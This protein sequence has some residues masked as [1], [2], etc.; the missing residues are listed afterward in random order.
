MIHLFW[1]GGRVPTSIRENISRWKDSYPDELLVWRDSE[2]KTHLYPNEFPSGWPL[3]MIVDLLRVR[4][5][6]KMGGWYCDADTEPGPIRLRQCKGIVLTREESKRFWNGFF[7]GE[8][9]HPF[10]EHWRLEIERSIGEFWP[11]ESYVP[12]ISGPHA[13]TR[14]IYTY[15]LHHGKSKSKR[16]ISF[17][18]WGFAEF[19]FGQSR[20]KFFNRSPKYAIRHM[21]LASWIDC[22]VRESNKLKT[23]QFSRMLYWARQSRFATFFDLVRNIL[24]HPRLIPNT[25]WK[26]HLLLNMDNRV[27][28]Q[29]N[30]WNDCEYELQDLNR[31]E[32]VVRNLNIG[33]IRTSNILISKRLAR[34]GWKRIRVEVWLRPNVVSLGELTKTSFDFEFPK[35]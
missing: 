24:K 34:A 16:D 26:L 21:A 32:S 27:I 15:A 25:F 33:V 3:A 23:S 7:F 18:N 31:L 8:K 17:T 4:A 22:E 9:E 30:R 6:Y 1:I 14:A 35:L 19:K 20:R 28:D 11:S 29:M 5:V 2:C 10:L 12:L 13:L